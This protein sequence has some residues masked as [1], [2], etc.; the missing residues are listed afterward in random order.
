MR[1]VDRRRLLLLLHA[2]RRRD[3]GG[4]DCRLRGR[5]CRPNIRVRAGR[6]LRTAII[7]SAAR[8]LRQRLD[9]VRRRRESLAA[10]RRLARLN[11]DAHN[12]RKRAALERIPRR[13]GLLAQNA[14]F[15]HYKCRL[16]L[17]LRDNRRAA[18]MVLS[19][20]PTALPQHDCL[21][22]IELI[23]SLATA[24]IDNQIAN[25]RSQQAKE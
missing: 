18:L 10:V 24:P 12:D 13:S 9:N 2:V 17:D 3:N 14:R 22:A 7:I 5:R 15:A 23:R 21:R 11:S 8:R 20:L 4:D 19:S 1:G 16:R 25:R 6:R